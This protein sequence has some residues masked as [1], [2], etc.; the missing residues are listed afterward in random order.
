[1]LTLPA[2]TSASA[3]SPQF[4]Q[5]PLCSAKQLFRGHSATHPPGFHLPASEGS[6]TGRPTS[7]RGET[8]QSVQLSWPFASPPATVA[9]P[10]SARPER[11]PCP[12]ASL[13]RCSYRR[14]G[15]SEFFQVPAIADRPRA[16]HEAS[17]HSAGECARIPLPLWESCERTSRVRAPTSAKRDRGASFIAG[18]RASPLAFARHW[19]AIRR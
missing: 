19:P 9:A 12:R 8:G 14:V 1:M 15:G 5:P 3:Q 2:S 11:V 7:C 10:R 16:F 4:P 17:H 6:P 13:R 18:P